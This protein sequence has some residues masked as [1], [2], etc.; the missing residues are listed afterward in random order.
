MVAAHAF[1]VHVV[2]RA[3]LSATKVPTKFFMG[4]RGPMTRIVLTHFHVVT[5]SAGKPRNGE[6][7]VPLHFLVML[8]HITI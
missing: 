5:L 8:T 1:S 7:Q 6:N 3:G 2:S 4:P